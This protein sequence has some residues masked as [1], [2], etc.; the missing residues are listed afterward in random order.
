MGGNPAYQDLDPVPVPDPVTPADS[1]GDAAGWA[2]VTPDGRGTAP[3]DI[4]AA[5]DEAAIQA[6]FDGAGRVSAAGI[7]VYPRPG[8]RQA[9]T[10]VLLDSPAG[11]SAG[12][13]TSGYDITAGWS[14]EPYDSWD[15][16][17]QPGALLET[18]IQGTG[19]YPGTTQDGV[20][21]YG[22]S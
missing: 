16:N 4:Q 12:G 22:T 21:T 11:F 2:M 1:P 7:S 17:P 18:P 5:S 13:G 20:Q 8:T 14:G 19:D 3:Y 10:A 6:A 15:N 9:E